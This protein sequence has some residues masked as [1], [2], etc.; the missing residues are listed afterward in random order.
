MKQLFVISVL[1][2]LLLS[3]PGC[4]RYYLTEGTAVGTRV[5]TPA[6]EARL[7]RVGFLTKGLERRIAVQNTGADRTATNTLEVWCLFRNRTNYDQQIMVRTQYFGPAR[8]PNEGPNEWQTLFLPS[9]GI[10][11]YRTYSAGTDAEYFYIEVKE[12]P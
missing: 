12:M 11:T 9:N 1:I 3:V 4:T 2:L 6:T 10:E 5:D 7:N 8:K